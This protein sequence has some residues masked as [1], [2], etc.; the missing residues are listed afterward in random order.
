MVKWNLNDIFKED[1]KNKLMSAMDS[2]VTKLCSF[3]NKLNS[4]KIKEFIEIFNLI[5][6]LTKI[7]NTLYIKIYLKNCEDQGDKKTIKELQKLDML[8][9]ENQNKLLFINEFIRNLDEKKANML[10]KNLGKYKYYFKSIRDTKPHMRSLEEE[11][12]LNLK[13]LS[14]HQTL[15]T[16]RNLLSSKLIFK[17]K[18]KKINETELIQHTMD[19]ASKNHI[20]AY[21]SL[22]SEYKKNEDLFGEVYKGL[23]L[24]WSN[25]MIKIRNHTTSISARNFS[26]T[27]QDSTIN[28]LL[29]LIREKRNI[30]QK[31]FKLKFKV[32]NLPNS[33]YHI[34][35]PYQIKTSKKYDFQTSKKL[36]LKTF[37]NFSPDVEKLA[38]NVFDKSHIHSDVLKSKRGGAFCYSYD[39]NTVPFIMLN[40][41]DDLNS[42]LTMAH[43]LGHGIHAQLAK[44]KTQ[45]TYHSSL[46]LAETASIFSELLLTEELL[47][48]ATNEEKKY[49]LFHHISAMFASILRQAYFVIFEIDA[50]KLISQ[51]ASVDDLNQ[52]YYDLLKEQFG[53]D[54]T[55]P[56]EF[57]C[58]WLRIP[59]IYE[60][61]FYCYAYA[62]GNLLV[63]ALYIKYQNEG[64]KFVK[65]YLNI[66]SSGGDADVEEILSKVKIDVNNKS[67]WKGA[68]DKLEKD[69]NDLENL[70][71]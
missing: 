62:F 59:H 35:A 11:K 8:L 30:F 68:F 65:D 49:L 18:N 56:D 47:K 16:I 28:M 46:V 1:D 33:R 27:L 13:N 60:S 7:S 38:K 52:K 43:E 25:E 20:E 3:K 17:F 21:K 53:D 40:H 31:F 50:H 48:I 37:K 71:N 69:V 34:Y 55:I 29:N 6:E 9:T 4:C 54:M 70:I 57:K 15:T 10:Y 66:L 5:E 2:S 61:P 24:D 58:E 64:T 32:L 19:K 51:G 44:D 39:K 42:I 14:G 63:L 23:A 22:L 12:I 26:N 41:T 36:V 67:F 45:M